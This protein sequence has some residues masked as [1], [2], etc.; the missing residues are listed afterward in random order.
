MGLRKRPYALD[1]V[2][3]RRSPWLDHLYTP[4]GK[5]RRG[6]AFYQKESVAGIAAD[7]HG[8][9]LHFEKPKVAIWEGVA[10]YKI[11]GGIFRLNVMEGGTLRLEKDDQGI[12]MSH[13]MFMD[14]PDTLFGRLALWIFKNILHGE[15]AVYNH[16]YKELAYFK[17]QLERTAGYA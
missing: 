9:F 8:R 1:C 10:T 6:A 15:K 7:L 12:R 3:P 2:K 5:A 13:D 17:K 4:D 16:G 11:L 14:F